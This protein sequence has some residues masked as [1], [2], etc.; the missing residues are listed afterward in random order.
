M[1]VT[2]FAADLVVDGLV[3][4]LRAASGFR[5][6]LEEGTDVPVY[7]GAIVS[8]DSA[9]SCVVV[10]SDGDVGGVQRP[11]RFTSEWH[12]MDFSTDETGQIQ[13]AVVVWSGDANP[14]TFADQRALAVGV[15]QDVDEA[16]RASVTAASLG[17]TRLLWSKV[18]SGELIQAAT[19]RGIETRLPF[20]Y[21]YRA[22]LQVT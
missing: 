14:D 6:P 12:D 3:A 21:G 16:L 7:D 8:S 9:L 4:A 5:S 17:V 15:L 22:L 13:C 19:S 10:G 11:F 18:D 20:T 2:S 1:E